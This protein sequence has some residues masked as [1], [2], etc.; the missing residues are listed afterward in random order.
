MKQIEA[1]VRITLYEDEEGKNSSKIDIENP[2]CIPE[3]IILAMCRHV[4]DSISKKMRKELIDI[5]APSNN[6]KD[7][8]N[9]LGDSGE[10]MLSTDLMKV[11]Q[12]FKNIKPLEG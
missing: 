12:I 3:A 9:R 4:G 10:A 5:T 7:Y 2:Y 6:L 8:V 1:V 11:E